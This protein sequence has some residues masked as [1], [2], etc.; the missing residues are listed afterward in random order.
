[1]PSQTEQVLQ[2]ERCNMLHVVMKKAFYVWLY[3]QASLNTF[4]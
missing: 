3:T 2:K 4:L 1:M